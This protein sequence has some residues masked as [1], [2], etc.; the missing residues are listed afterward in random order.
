MSTNPTA[1][2][3][4]AGFAAGF[5]ATRISPAILRQCG[6]ALADTLAVAIAGLREPGASRMRAYVEACGPC[7]NLGSAPSGFARLWGSDRAAPVEA[8]ALFNATVAHLLDFDDASSAM[9]GHPSVA[10]LPALVAL[11]EARDIDGTRLASAYVVGFEVCCKL[12]RALDLSHYARGWHMTASVGTLAA[13][14]ACGHLIGLDPAR[15]VNALGLAV[16]STA[17][18]RENFGTDAKSFQ[19]G[20]CNAAALRAVLLAE[21]DFTAAAT[22]LDGKAGYTA[23]YSAGEPVAEALS[24]LGEEPL[25]IETSGI[26]VKRYAACYGIHRPLDGLFDLAGNRPLDPERIGRIEVETSY[27]GLA[28]LIRHQPRSGTEGKFSLEYSL[29]AAVT[30]GAIRLAS[31]TDEAVARPALRALMDRI[32]AR[33]ASGPMIPRWAT[34]AVHLTNGE[35]LSRRVDALHGAPQAP[36]S[37]GELMAKIADC[38]AWSGAPIDPSALFEAALELGTRRVRDILTAAERP[39]M[40]ERRVS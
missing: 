39:L 5:D 8:A 25:E 34:V 7:A 13:A 33:E 22:A 6:R 1:S 37:D 40:M 14:A 9:S 35:V 30:D 19:V 36:L 27:G 28:V 26:E 10:L 29:A 17:G 32:A 2:Q 16:A 15:L 20:H 3:I 38:V 4:V 21:Q 18:T 11:A 24:R 12:G 31:Y 23:L